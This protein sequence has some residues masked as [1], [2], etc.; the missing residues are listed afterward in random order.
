LMEGKFFNLIVPGQFSEDFM[1]G[2]YAI[3]TH[4]ESRSKVIGSLMV[5]RAAG[6]FT[7]LSFGA[8]GLLARPSLLRHPGLRGLL[9]ACSVPIGATLAGIVFLRVVERPPQFIL[10][11]AARLHLH[12][13]IDRMYAEG[14]F[15]ATNFPVMLIA[16]AYTLVNQA[17]MV[18]C[19]YLLGTTLA[20]SSVGALDYMVFA[21]CGML[22]TILP[23]APVGL[24]VGQGAFLVLFRMAGSEQGANL[25]SLYTLMAILLNLTGA[26]FYLRSKGKS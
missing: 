25:F 21:P 15:Y 5:D 24:G 19:F 23:V 4:K 22:A 12:I 18:G 16:V 6:V 11:L 13:A 3:R 1:R 20:M 8:V 7:M 2:L 26:I 17:A 9:L 10:A 14:R